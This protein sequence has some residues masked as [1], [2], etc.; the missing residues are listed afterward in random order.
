MN[1]APKTLHDDEKALWKQY[2]GNYTDA[3]NSIRH[4]LARLSETRE[5]VLRGLK[6][7]AP[8]TPPTAAKR[9]T[10][11]KVKRPQSNLTA[12]QQET[13]DTLLAIQSLGLD[14]TT[15]EMARWLDLDGRKAYNRIQTLA[16]K[17]VVARFL[18]NEWELEATEEEDI[19]F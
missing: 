6:P 4:L 17:G 15:A 12:H 13:L 10:A 18:N 8:V 19:L 7:R 2:R 5:K 1:E 11:R 3:A 9:R 14:Q 16:R